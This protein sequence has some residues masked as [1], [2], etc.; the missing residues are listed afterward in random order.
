MS[1]L[2][3]QI[4]SPSVLNHAWNHVRKDRARWNQEL[5]MADVEQD[6]PL[7]IGRIADELLSGTYRAQSLRCFEIAK[8]NGEARTIC[9]P[10][11]R[12]KFVQRAVLT[13]LEPIAESYFHPCSF[14]YRPLCTIDMALAKVREWVRQGYTWLGD[15]DIFQCFDSIAHTAV[16]KWV[17]ALTEEPRITA[18]IDDW[19]NAVPDQYRPYGAGFSLPQGQVISPF[20]CNLYLHEMDMDLEEAGIPFVRFADDFIVFG[21][22]QATAEQ[23][24]ATA[25][26]S[27]ERLGLRFNEDKTHVIQSSR[28]HQFLGKRLPNANVRFIP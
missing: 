21:S 5:T 25:G 17:D 13:V 4:V 15:A 19:L 23:A 28:K 22:D 24:L 2:I 27:L 20:L 8:V 16:L 1:D 14:G 12:D 7:H 11:V 6:L 3:Q 18:L 26:A 10:T 9:A